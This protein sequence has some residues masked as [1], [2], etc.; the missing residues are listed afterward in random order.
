MQFN[1]EVRYTKQSVLY[2]E[3]Q[4]EPSPFVVVEK[5][6]LIQAGVF[7]E[8]FE[9]MATWGGSGGES[10]LILQVLRVLLPC[11]FLWDL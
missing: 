8:D 6:S 2:N 1:E 7:R 5:S 9:V 4:M 10:L 11:G 3:Y